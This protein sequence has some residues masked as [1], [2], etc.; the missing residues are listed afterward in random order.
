[1][2]SKKTVLEIIEEYAPLVQKLLGLKNVSVEWKVMHS[3]DPNNCLYGFESTGDAG[4]C[5]WNPEIPED[6]RTYII[7][8]F[9]DQQRNKSDTIGTVLHEL[10][11]VRF[12]EFD[13]FID[14]CKHGALEE[15]FIS[16]IERLILKLLER[17]Q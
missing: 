14:F 3:S 6:C 10:M 4:Q 5:V 17:R 9:Y 13:H 1:V 7:A 8:V 16:D 2:V 12:R 15:K 11:H